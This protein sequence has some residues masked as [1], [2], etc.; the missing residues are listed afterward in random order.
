MAEARL[1][2]DNTEIAFRSRSTTELRKAKLLFLSFG[3]PTLLSAGPKL[4]NFA[5]SLRLP[6][7]PLIRATIFEQFCGG[8][9]FE[10]CAKTVQDLAEYKIR[11]VLD[12]SVEGLGTEA[13]FDGARSEIL[14]V[15][16]YSK[17]NP[18]IPFAVFK[19]T[20]VGRIAL[21]EKASTK[22][23]LSTED[24]QELGRV[25]ARVHEISAAAKGAGLRLLFDAEESWIQPYIDDLALRTMREFNRDRAV[26]YNTLQMY[27]VRRLG[28]LQE[29]LEEGKAGKFHVGVKLVRGAYM[30]KERAR[31]AAKH[32]ASPIQPDKAATDRDFDAAL[33]LSVAN[34]ERLALFAGSHNEHSNHHLAELIVKRGL[35]YDD[36]R[37]EFSQLLGMSDNLTYNL[38]DRGFNVTKYVPYGPIRAVIPYLT[39]RAA[40]N[41]S[42]KGQAGRELQLIDRELKRRG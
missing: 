10:D 34:L 15:I 20:G 18:N 9:T 38:A 32:H 40:E 31:A 36:P 39:R 5:L 42:I 13:A 1:D 28:S 27:L 29:L 11:S 24:K 21:L 35:K 12:Y 2:F 16:A 7:T 6:I 30:E 8:V 3:S 4:V 23:K 19:V 37:V 14:K 25:E 22:A 26:I 17:G 33:D 41:S